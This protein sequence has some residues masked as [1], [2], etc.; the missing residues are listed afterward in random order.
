MKSFM[1]PSCDQAQSRPVQSGAAQRFP[2]IKRIGTAYGAGKADCPARCPMQP[3][4]KGVLS[5]RPLDQRPILSLDAHQCGQARG[6]DDAGKN[7]AWTGGRCR[8]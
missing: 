4:A 6:R 7:R 1:G 5:V 3:S 2:E 8:S